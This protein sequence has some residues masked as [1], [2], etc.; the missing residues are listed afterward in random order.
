MEERDTHA[1]TGAF[2]FSGKY[3]ARRLLDRGRRVISLTD[4]IDR[5]NPF[6]AS[7]EARPF[8]FDDPERLTDNLRDVRVLYNT[9][10]I[11]FNHRTFTHAEAIRNTL[12]LFRCAES[13]GVE[14]LVHVSITNPSLD[15][16][17]EYFRGKAEL[18]KALSETGI[19]YCVL[20][21]A[22]LFGDEDIL[23]NNIA[24]F[25][26]RF[27]LFGVFGRG[28]YA[29]QPIHVD[30]LARLAVEAGE[31]SGSSVI[32]AIGP[33]TFSFREL[34]ETLGRVIGKP[35]PI[36]SIPPFIGRWVAAI[37]GALLGDVV[38]TREEIAGLMAGHLAVDAPPAGKT[39][40]SEWAA[41]N[42]DRL[43]QR[44]ANELGRRRDRVH[45]YD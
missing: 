12:T 19:G 38:L 44:Y 20:R 45:R 16:P 1:V 40:L 39:K 9:Y 15:S 25:L 5:H 17:L 21:P 23:I 22:V 42:A 41:Q 29:I 36:V 26:R 2:G 7:V 13:A 8:S 10:W 11:R 37:A 32:E 33:E 30:D 14:R 43:G 18:E 31:A 24:W 28:D 4:S 27:P 6:D 34:V 3:I 35:R